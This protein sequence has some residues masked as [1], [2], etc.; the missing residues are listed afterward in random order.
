VFALKHPDLKERQKVKVTGTYRIVKKVG[1]YT[2]HNVI[3]A[4]EVKPQR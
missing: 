3:E 4:T 2:L 1:K